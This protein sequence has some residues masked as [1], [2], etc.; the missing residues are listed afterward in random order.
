ML[1]LRQYQLRFVICAISRV[2]PVGYQ[3]EVL[4]SDGNILLF[5]RYDSGLVYMRLQGAG[6][7]N[8]SGDPGC[9]RVLV[10]L[11]GFSKETTN[12]MKKLVL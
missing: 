6:S 10:S 9:V 4:V 2:P 11:V 8:L 12:Y 5:L 7:V 1:R 3:C